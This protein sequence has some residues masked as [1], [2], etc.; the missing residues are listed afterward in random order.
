MGWQ[1]ALENFDRNKG[2]G[3]CRVQA[4]RCSA[5]AAEFRSDADAPR[6][7]PSNLQTDQAEPLTG[8]EE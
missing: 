8:T 7:D 6:F 3:T 5:G 4:E 2:G 1:N